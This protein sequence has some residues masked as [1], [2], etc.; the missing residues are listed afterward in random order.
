MIK[1]HLTDDILRAYAA[2]TLA[3]AFNL[4]VATHIS[5]CDTCRAALAAHEAVGGSLLEDS[6]GAALSDDAFE[7]TLR[8]ISTDPKDPIKVEV[9]PPAARSGLFPP[10]LRDYVGGDLDAVR[11]RPLGMGVRQAVLKTS[12]AASARLLHIPAGAAVP[13]HGHGGLEMTLV[14]RGA[15]VDAAA[16]FAAGDV[17]I[18]NE[19]VSHMPVAEV[20]E[21]CICLT[22]TDAPLRFNTLIPRLAQPFLRI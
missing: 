21:D 4:V 22:A 16:R 2:G 18:A 9:E 7:K 20:A 13:D 3:E 5:M 11:W 15:F 6:E 12:R 17:E 14:L 1:H 10:P 8:L 19:D